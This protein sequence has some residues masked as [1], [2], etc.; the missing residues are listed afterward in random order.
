MVKKFN[1]IVLHWTAGGYY[2]NKMEK[3]HYH[4]L[5]DKDGKC[6][7]GNHDPED[8]LNCNDGNYAAHTGGGN[9]GAIGVALCGMYGFKNLKEPGKSFITKKQCET[10]FHLVAMI[11]RKY[12]MSL[13]SVVTHALF[14]LENPKTSSRG[15]IDITVLPPCYDTDKNLIKFCLKYGQTKGIN[16]YIKHKVKWYYDNAPEVLI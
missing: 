5:I 9:T 11:L 15:K 13:D 8:N 12:N 10:M 6:Y 7:E 1:K 3:E 14:G 4:Y 2:P 16:E